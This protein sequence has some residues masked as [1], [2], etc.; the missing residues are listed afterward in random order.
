MYPQH[1]AEDSS[2][3]SGNW[4]PSNACDRSV[5]SLQRALFFLPQPFHVNGHFRGG[6]CRTPQ[7]VQNKTKSGLQV[8]LHRS[9]IVVQCTCHLGHQIDFDF[10]F[11]WRWA[12]DLERQVEA[13][14][15]RDSTGSFAQGEWPC[16]KEHKI[17]P[18][19]PKWNSC[20]IISVARVSGRSPPARSAYSL[21]GK[22]TSLFQSCLPLLQLPK[23]A[24][25]IGIPWW[26]QGAFKRR[27]RAAQ[28]GSGTDIQSRARDGGHSSSSLRDLTH[29]VRG[30][31][32][33]SGADDGTLQSC[34]SPLLCCSKPRGGSKAS[35]P[36]LLRRLWKFS[37]L[38]VFFEGSSLWFYCNP[39][40][41]FQDCTFFPNNIRTS[42]TNFCHHP[43]SVT[44]YRVGFQLQP[45]SCDFYSC[46]SERE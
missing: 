29:A 12:P 35:L 37:L 3:C 36:P 30:N 38:P 24:R 28:G 2:Y 7:I 22:E 25:K 46:L 16:V 43:T 41:M 6:G 39:L 11:W 5:G 31:V 32:R 33:G 17:S 45:R 26:C 13:D 19:L 42:L 1:S 15:I 20:H 18:R 10:W 44:T 14:G 4:L 27:R 34:C 8:C 21:L 40:G 9:W 23:G